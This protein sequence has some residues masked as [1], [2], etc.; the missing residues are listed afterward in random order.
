MPWLN[1]PAVATLSA[2]LLLTPQVTV[3][4]GTI[5][6]N[7]AGAEGGG[8][9][10]ATDAARLSLN[11]TAVHWN[12]AAGAGGGVLLAGSAVMT[13]AHN[14]V[15]FNKARSGGGIAVAPN[16][17]VADVHAFLAA[18]VNNTAAAGP[19]VA[20]EPARIV[21][22]SNI[23]SDGYV[24]RATAEGGALALR[25]A[26][27]GAM[28]LP[29]P[30]VL[31][32]ATLGAL[33]ALGANASDDA[34]IVYMFLRIRQ[35]AGHYTLS[36]ALPE[37]TQVAP[38]SF[39]LYVRG[40]IPGEVAPLPNTCEPCVPGYY[41]LDPTQ[42]LCQLCPAG[43]DCPGGAAIIPQPGWWQSAATSAQMHR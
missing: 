3:I 42:A 6:H 17:T 43:A 10:V 39:S 22:V 18:V 32:A 28:D 23:S 20:A 41:S 25:L 9:L 5:A 36:V 14:K 24:S 1:T 37:Y 26:V 2:C 40:C 4:N 7:R 33:Q 19:N 31:A 30:G 34:G 13:A 15:M 21:L 11:S 29:A 16:A 38:A 8:G 27:S 35:P 12:N